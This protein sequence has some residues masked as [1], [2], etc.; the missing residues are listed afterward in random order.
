MVWFIVYES[1]YATA[2]LIRKRQDDQTIT[3]SGPEI[4]P[5][6]QIRQLIA[7]MTVMEAKKSNPHK[8]PA[9]KK[10]GHKPKH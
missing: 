7:R 4:D 3:F 1:D 9:K 5:Q 2:T 10:H 6:E 8:S